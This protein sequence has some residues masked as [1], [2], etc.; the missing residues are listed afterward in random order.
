MDFDPIFL[1][2]PLLVCAA[3]CDL[4]FLRIPDI[5]SVALVVV[6]VFCTLLSAPDQL[7]TTLLAAAIVFALGFLAFGFRLIGGGDVKLL[8]AL[9]LFIPPPELIVFANVFS[10]SLLIGVATIV[11]LR[12]SKVAGMAGWKSLSQPRSFPMGLSIALA[13][14]AF[15]F[16]AAV[17]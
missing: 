16:I 7:M 9:M 4:R 14:V 15:P 3:Y 6:F 2:A 1:A 13:G 12:R 11:A 10:G 8:S 5:I 17:I